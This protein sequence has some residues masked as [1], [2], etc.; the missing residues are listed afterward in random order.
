M[1]D[2][3]KLEII[4]AKFIS[5]LESIAT[6]TEFKNLIKNINRERVIIFIKEALHSEGDWRTNVSGP[7]EITKGQDLYDLEDEVDAI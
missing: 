2:N 5:K 1:D 4:K 7:E 6:L 3:Q